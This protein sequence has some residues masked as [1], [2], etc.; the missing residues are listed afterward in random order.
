M[1]KRSTKLKVLTLN[2]PIEI[3]AVSGYDPVSGRFCCPLKEALGLA[4][5]GGVTPELAARLCF[6]ATL[7]LSYDACAQIARQ[8]GV[9]VN[10]SMVHRYVQNWGGQLAAQ[11]AAET[12]RI[13][14]PETRG[15]ALAE[16]ADE[17]G[18]EPFDLVVMLDGWMIR[19][20][21]EE[22][23]APPADETPARVAWREM[24][25][26]IVFRLN[27]RCA[28]QSGRRVLLEKYYEAYRGNPFEFGQRLFALALRHGLR[29]ARRVIVI[30]DGAAW[31]WNLVRDRFGRVVELLDFYH[32]SQHLW[33]VAE[34]LYP[35]APEAAR[36]WAE[37][38]LHRLRHGGGQPVEKLLA[39]LERRAAGLPV[40]RAEVVEANQGY[41]EN[42]RGRMAYRIVERLGA[43]V[44]SG[45]MESTCSQFQDR[46]KRTGQFWTR[47]GA[48]RL[49][50]LELA[51]RNDDWDRLWEKVA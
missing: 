23:G 4:G 32:A 51:R 31:I 24:K 49:M 35:G 37:P 5:C 38:L 27:E 30:A 11:Q 43:P 20:R 12:E 42:H 1:R 9:P 8:W 36:A 28:T 15:E 7:S 13:L 39:E 26:G 22:W 3:A 47:P 33:A 46:F 44:G 29:Q 18:P 45:A 10:D 50:A 16:L 25:A 48:A 2:G 19:E 6:T 34:A 17:R 14:E 40:E 21:G 41:F